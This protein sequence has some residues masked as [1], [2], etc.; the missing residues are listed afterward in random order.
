[1]RWPFYAATSKVPRTS[2]VRKTVKSSV[3][4]VVVSGLA[5][6]LPRAHRAR[7]AADETGDV[8]RNAY[9]AAAARPL[10]RAPSSEAMEEHGESGPVVLESL[11]VALCPVAA[12]TRGVR[13]P[14]TL[15]LRST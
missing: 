4:R 8:L 9:G 12:S 15:A 13:R 11:C 3:A 14:S 10:G 1:M 7:E 6:T 5:V 2:V